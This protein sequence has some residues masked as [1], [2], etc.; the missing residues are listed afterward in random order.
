MRARRWVGVVLLVGLA[1]TGCAKVDEDGESR[2]EPAKL[3]KVAGSDLKKIV[4]SARAAER[5]GIV[6]VAVRQEAAPDSVAV[7]QIIPYSA[8]VYDPQGQTWT[9][10]N[11][12]RLTYVRHRI[13]VLDIDRDTALL[14]EG[15]PPGTPVVTV[16][17]AELFGIEYEV[18][19]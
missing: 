3:V 15:P 18:G 13:A 10:T 17:A 12:E 2:A 4:L 1:G 6:T 7:R 14:S 9:Y 16:G 5:L 19:Y 8:V 11:P